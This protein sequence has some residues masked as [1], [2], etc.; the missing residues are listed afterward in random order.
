M[1]PSAN[2]GQHRSHPVSVTV[3]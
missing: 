1:L 2:L 3:M